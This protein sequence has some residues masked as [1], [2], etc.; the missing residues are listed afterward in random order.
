MISRPILLRCNPFWQS[1]DFLD[2]FG[3]SRS[4]CSRSFMLE[5]V[6][7]GSSKWKLANCF[8]I[9]MCTC[10]FILMVNFLL[11]KFKFQY[12]W[13][14]CVRWYFFL[15]NFF[16]HVKKLLNF[17]NFV[18]IKVAKAKLDHFGFYCKLDFFDRTIRK[19]T[20]WNR[21]WVLIDRTPCICWAKFGYSGHK[22]KWTI[23]N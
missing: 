11:C 13:W 17:W 12:C 15:G 16:Q 4:V 3:P 2:T 8:V 14:W 20:N 21:N 19:I 18:N 7:Q 1:S 6:S 9:Y 22:A 10:L 23:K 5:H